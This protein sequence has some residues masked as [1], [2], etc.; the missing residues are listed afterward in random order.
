MNDHNPPGDGERVDFDELA[1][2]QAK[3]HE[4]DELDGPAWN[5]DRTLDDEDPQDGS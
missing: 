5:L 1:I 4:P 3:K 2:D